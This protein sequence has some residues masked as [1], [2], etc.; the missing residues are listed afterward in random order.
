VVYNL[1]SK[2][3]VCNLL[4]RVVIQL[5]ANT[6]KVLQNF[7]WALWSQRFI[8]CRSRHFRLYT[9]SG[10]VLGEKAGKKRLCWNRTDKTFPGG[11]MD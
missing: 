6:Y 10:T 8:L 4:K 1:L 3:F 11:S 2:Y 5:H 9:P 7:R